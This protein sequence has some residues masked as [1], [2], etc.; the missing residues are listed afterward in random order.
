M[1]RVGR[2][3][4]FVCGSRCEIHGMKTIYFVIQSAIFFVSMALF[5]P[6]AAKAQTGPDINQQLRS[7]ITSVRKAKTI[8]AS[9]DASERLVSL[10][11]EK[12]CS[13][14]SDET[15]N[16]MVSLLNIPND[17]VRMWVAGALG[18]I[19]PRA[20]VAVPKLLKILSDV[21]CNNL[22]LSSASTIPVALRKMGVIP[23]PSNCSR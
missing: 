21:Q 17:I 13:G 18:N 9:S 11:Y 10:T 15:I 16:S 5:L 2:W 20:K 3:Y 1:A 8:T 12:D 19:G 14:V 6:S 7:A 23:P 4:A 22:D